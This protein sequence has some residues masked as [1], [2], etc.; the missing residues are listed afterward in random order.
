[1]IASFKDF[2]EGVIVEELHPELKDIVSSVDVGKSKQARIATKVKD[3]TE[4]GERTGIEGNM[5]TGSSRAYLKHDTNHKITLDGKPAIIPVG[6]KVA[7][8]ATLDKHHKHND[9]DGHSLGQLQNKAEAGDHWVNQNYRVFSEHPDKPGEFKTNHEGI[10]P[11]LIDHDHETHHW[12]KVGH[13][14]NIKAKEFQELTKTDTHPKGITHKDFTHA[15]NRFHERNNGKYYSHDAKREA[16]LDHVDEHPLV[17]KFQDYHGNTGHPTYDYQ[18]LQNMGTFH[19]PDGHKMI[20]ARDHGF[21]TDVHEAYVN[22][23][24]TAAKRNRRRDYKGDLL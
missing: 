14:K 10:F 18:Q 22:A 13:V 16:H 8:R 1:M 7:I 15:M 17:Q 20:V 21:D 9:Y 24:A 19:H 12:S 2:M 6:T 5:P 4:R 3:L 11:P 23:R